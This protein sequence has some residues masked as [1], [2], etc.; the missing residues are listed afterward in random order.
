MELK[1]TIIFIIALSCNSLANILM[2]ASA[3]KTEYNP[4]WNIVPEPLLGYLNPF[5]LLGLFSFGL[6]LIG[7]KMVLSKLKLSIAYP[8]F[9]SAGFIFVLLASH[10]FF[11]EKLTNLQW[12]GIGLILV[13]VW[14][15][16]FGMMDE[17]SP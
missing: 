11:H 3:L 14:L 1:I 9:T 5:F 8:I 15:T 16:A 2:K 10:F 13:G 6:A 17:V 12:I 4:K 7:Y